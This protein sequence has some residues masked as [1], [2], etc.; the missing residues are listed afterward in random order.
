MAWPSGS[1]QEDS[2]GCLRKAKVSGKSSRE[3]KSSKLVTQDSPAKSRAREQIL[4]RASCQSCSVMSAAVWKASRLRV[5]GMVARLCLPWP[6]L[7]SRLQPPV[8]R[9]LKVSF[10]VFHLARPAAAGSAKFWAVTGNR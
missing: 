4:L 1:C 6:K 10:P 7:C 5:T 8:L 3:E 2:G 9:M